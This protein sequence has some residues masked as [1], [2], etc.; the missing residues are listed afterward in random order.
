MLKQTFSKTDSYHIEWHEGEGQLHIHCTVRLWK[1]SVL[2]S[3]YREFINLRQFIRGLGY[4]CFYSI[5]PN[6]KFCELFCGE[7][8]GEQDGQEVMMWVV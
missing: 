6:P 5:S 1:K 7:S 3:L 8:I 4:E 2:R